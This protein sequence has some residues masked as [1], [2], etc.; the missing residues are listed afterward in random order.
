MTYPNAAGFKEPTTS[1]EA[2]ESTDAPRLR[3]MVEHAMRIFGPMTADETA[4]KLALPILSV[5]PRLS[6]LRRLGRIVS[7]G[8]RRKNR[9]GKSAIVWALT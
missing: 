7:T 5:R 1:R 2:A 3:A 8:Q 9:S 6:E 4:Y